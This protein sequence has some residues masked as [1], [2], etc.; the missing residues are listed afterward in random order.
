MEGPGG[1][2]NARVLAEYDPSPIEFAPIGA[3]D[4]GP[5]ST[6]AIV[7]AAAEMVILLPEP[8][9]FDRSEVEAIGPWSDRLR[10]CFQTLRL[11]LGWHLRPGHW[12]A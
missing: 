6:A 7:A 9:C 3:E 4:L 2:S 5:P 10:L 1:K 12:P 8:S 11:P